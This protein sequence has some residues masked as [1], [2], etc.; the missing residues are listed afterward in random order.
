M[1]KSMTMT[2]TI[3]AVLMVFSLIFT[4]PSGSVTEEAEMAYYDAQYEEGD[5]A[6]S[7]PQPKAVLAS[8][9]FS[10]ILPSANVAAL[11]SGLFSPGSTPVAENFTENGY[12]DDTIIVELEQRR[13]FDSDVFIAYVKIAHPSQ[14]RTA[15]AGNKLS[16][17]RTNQTTVITAA[18]NGIVGI[19]GDYYSDKD[20]QGGHIVRMGETMRER[21]SDNFDLLFIDELGDLHVFH[22]GK[23][24]QQAQVDAFKSEHE[25][26]NA[27]CFGPGLVINGEKPEDVSKYKWFDATGENP[28]AGIGQIDMLTYVLVA[29]NGRTSESVGVTLDQFADIMLELGCEQA[30]NLDGGNSATLA[31]NGEVFNTKVQKERDVSDVIYFASAIDAE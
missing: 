10:D 3:L 11:D 30:Y 26:V 12:R 17:T 20:R 22:R 29:V 25:I 7:L 24:E 23:A 14:L 5:Y 19:N 16:S 1:R 27:F 2:A 31:F 21:V 18:Y 6:V 4:I 9:V 28:R 15:I 13:M 8:A